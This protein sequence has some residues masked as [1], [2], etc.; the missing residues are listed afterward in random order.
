MELIQICDDPLLSGLRFP[1]SL[2]PK[3]PVFFGGDCKVLPDITTVGT[4]R[5]RGQ[6]MKVSWVVRDLAASVNG[7]GWSYSA[8]ESSCRVKLWMRWSRFSKHFL[9]WKISLYTVF[10]VVLWARSRSLNSHAG[11][12]K[13]DEQ[14]G[15]KYKC[16]WV[17]KIEMHAQCL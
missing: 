3:E 5:Q 9:T 11:T 2:C 17:Q 6:W 10:I 8:S 1:S 16:I 14:M 7:W 15:L 12:Q 13:V 4:I